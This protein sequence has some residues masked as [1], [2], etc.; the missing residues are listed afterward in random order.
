M[1][2]VDDRV[3]D[4]TNRINKVSKNLDDDYH[5]LYEVT[6]ISEERLDS[7]IGEALISEIEKLVVVF[8]TTNPDVFITG[9]Q[10]MEDENGNMIVNLDWDH[11]VPNE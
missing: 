5:N 6:N 2:T 3:K 4:L 11:I 9:I 1:E 8:E 10:R 7:I